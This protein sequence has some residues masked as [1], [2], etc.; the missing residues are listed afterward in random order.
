MHQSAFRLKP[1]PANHSRNLLATS[2]L[3]HSAAGKSHDL[4][5]LNLDGPLKIRNNVIGLGFAYR[6]VN[7]CCKT[8]P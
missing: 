8:V 5:A 6:S 1:N 7:P 4:I 3:I 2:G